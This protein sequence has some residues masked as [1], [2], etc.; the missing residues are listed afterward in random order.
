M[1]RSGFCAV[2]FSLAAGSAAVFHFQE[3]VVVDKFS[4]REAGAWEFYCGVGGSALVAEDLDAV[5]PCGGVIA[6]GTEIENQFEVGEGA[7]DEVVGGAGGAFVGVVDDDD[8]VV[9]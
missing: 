8:C 2:P 7:R 6:W 4:Y 9:G 5:P 1:G 3:D